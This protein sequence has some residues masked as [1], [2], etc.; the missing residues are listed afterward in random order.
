MINRDVSCREVVAFLLEYVAGE[1]RHDQ[2]VVIDDHLQ[3]C[4]ACLRYLDGYQRAVV[5]GRAAF[6]GDDEIVREAPPD[7]LEGIVAAIRN[8]RSSGP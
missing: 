7:L 8:A 5:S 6:R 4:P 1:L 3:K 2:R